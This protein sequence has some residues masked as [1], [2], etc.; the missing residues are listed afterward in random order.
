MEE[1]RLAATR[2]EASA[3]LVAEEDQLIRLVAMIAVLPVV[4]L[5]NNLTPRPMG[6]HSAHAVSAEDLVEPDS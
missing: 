5:E 1:V 6:M 2:L 3:A 4:D